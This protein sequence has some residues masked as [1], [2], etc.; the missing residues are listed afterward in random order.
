[1]AKVTIYVSRHGES[2]FN[3]LGLIGGDPGLSPEGQQYAQKLNGWVGTHCKSMQAMAAKEGDSKTMKVWYS[4]MC[5]AKETA[6]AV[7][8]DCIDRKVEYRALRE[9]DVGICDG[10]SYKE[11]EIKYPQEFQART[12]DKLRYRYP[13]GESY[14]DL[15]QR[16]EPVILELE[17]QDCPVL[18]IAH[19]ALLRCLYAYFREIPL[20]E[21][22]FISVPLHTVIEL[23]HGRTGVCNEQRHKLMHVDPASEVTQGGHKIAVQDASSTPIR[24]SLTSA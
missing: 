12:D 3:V 8:G 16:L 2:M 13:R 7:G 1:M 4:P 21:V 5:R 6:E 10:M 14:L 24:N 20:E 9:I 17:R 22:P 18:V 15:V 23:N 11:I 19:Q